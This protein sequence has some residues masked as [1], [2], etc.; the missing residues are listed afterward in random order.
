MIT[1]LKWNR[2]L[3]L[4][5]TNKQKHTQKPKSNTSPTPVDIIPATLMKQLLLQQ[6]FHSN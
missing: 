4:F 3:P 2:L 1:P 6:N 5:K